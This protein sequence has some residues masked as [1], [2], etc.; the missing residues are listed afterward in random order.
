MNI[1]T[2]SRT[3]AR[4]DWH[5]ALGRFK[6]IRKFYS[7]FNLFLQRI[8][9][10][11]FSAEIVKKFPIA[12]PLFHD[13][14]INTTLTALKQDAVAF[15]FNL[16]SSI[17]Q[18][19]KHF[20]QQAEYFRTEDNKLFTLQEVHDGKL[21]DQTAIIL[22]MARYPLECDAVQKICYEPLLLQIVEKYLGYFPKKITPRLFWSFVH[23]GFS[24]EY[25]LKCWQTVK[26]HFDVDGYNFIYAN[27][28]I[29][30]VDKQSGAHQM[31]KGSHHHK[32]LKMLFH[33]AN[34][35]DQSIYK[36]FG[37]EKEITIEGRAGLG[38]LQ[39]SSC[40]HK[41]LAPIEQPRLLLQVRFK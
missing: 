31:I 13:I 34:Q 33:S 10:F 14:D 2:I 23:Q 39:D 21:P 26:Y 7:F 11:F 38:F 27:F 32:P 36:H 25:R 6:S 1:F 28:Y 15:G 12:T 9:K 16:P 20:S 22:G 19:I 17:V 8:Q 29:T 5:Y 24:D 37:K 40:Y 30:P 4:G 3:L 35:S 41:A 18:E